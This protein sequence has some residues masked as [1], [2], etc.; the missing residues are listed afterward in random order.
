MVGVS[1]AATPSG[2][3]ILLR[4]LREVMGGEGAAQARM[5]QLVTTIAANMVAEV[6]SI[7]LLRDGVLELFATEGL[8]RDAV[9][10]TTLRIGEG[11]VGQIAQ[12][13]KPMAL[14]EARS[15]PNFAARPETGEEDYH[16]LMG[17]PV[18]RGG[19]VVGVLVLQNRSN[20]D[21]SNDEVEAMQT[22]AMVLA[23]MVGGA[24]QEEAPGVGAIGT[25][26]LP[27]RLAGLSLN[28]GLARGVAVLH[29]PRIVV[30]RHVADDIDLETARLTTALTELRDQVDGMLQAAVAEPGGESRD[31]LETYRMFAHDKGWMGR[32]H[33]AIQGGFTAEAA[34]E[35]VQVENRAR[36]SEISDAYLRERLH[37]LEDLSNRLMRH[38]TQGG[39]MPDDDLPEEAVVV[40]WNMGP[41]ELLDYD[42]DRIK[43]LVLEEGS[44]TSHVAIVARALQI[45]VVGRLENLLDA[46]ESGDD[47]VVDGDNG[48]LFVRPAAD[49]LEAFSANL[50][51]R[52]AKA[53]QYAALRDQPAVSKDGTRIQLNLNAGLLADLPHL[54]GT[55]ADGIGLYRTELH[56]MVRATLPTV[57]MQTEFYSRVLD[58]AGDRPVV[59]RTLDVGGDKILPYLARHDDEQNPAMGWRAIRLSLD[60]PVLLRMQIRA[61]LKAAAGRPLAIMFP[62]IAEVS[63]FK[64]ARA[65]LDREVERQQRMGEPTSSSLQ[66]GTM[67]EVPSLAWQ[68]PALLPLVDFVS[69]GSNDLMQFLF[70]SDRGNPRLANRYDEL[71]PSA[72]SLVRDIVQRCDAANVPV[73]LCGEA[74]GRPVDAMALIGLGLRS[75]SMGAA[76]I[77]AVKMMVR[78]LDLPLLQTFM[79]GFYDSPEHSFRNALIKFADDHNVAI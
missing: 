15:H 24:L 69:I 4:R 55:G 28:E 16:S 53:A 6:C 42:V 29:A 2:P 52:Q 50:E 59:F 56:F 65:L 76:S 31:I 62:M 45:P 11:L 12:L 37:D 54:A 3:R 44:P 19:R 46:V 63:E 43:A 1:P 39:Q 67:L 77:G 35:R 74:A 78:S 33:D 26:G 66:V 57:S 5:D 14:S 70:A 51:M 30:E 71:S 25:D 58:Q 34:V 79:E 23:E 9:H 27:R 60:R 36:M 18:L 17:V 20:R 21:Y 75:I 61:L 32:M 22:I 41:A 49:A 40:A 48:Q 68:L 38:L 10:Q 64:D 7:Y 8:N 47:L 72:L 73:S 13:A